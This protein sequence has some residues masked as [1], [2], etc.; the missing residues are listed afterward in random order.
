MRRTARLLLPTLLTAGVMISPLLSASPARAAFLGKRAV[1]AVAG[2]K[3]GAS[4][5]DVWLLSSTGARLDNITR[6]F[7]PAVSSP[8]FSPEG[9]P[10]IVFVAHGDLYVVDRQSPGGG[11]MVHRVT[12]GRDHDDQPSF[13]VTG[14]KIVFART[15]RGGVPRLLIANLSGSKVQA[16]DYPKG[17]HTAVKGSDPAWSPYQSEVAYVSGDAGS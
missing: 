9:G 6:S 12:S 7:S 5:S 3:T 1:M 14:G 10:H 8:A 2:H 15:P 4:G 16:L 17:S 11:H 13:D